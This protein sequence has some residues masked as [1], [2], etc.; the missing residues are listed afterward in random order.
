MELFLPVAPSI[1]KIMYQKR[2]EFE[3]MPEL[4]GSIWWPYLNYLDVCDMILLLHTGI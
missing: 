4:H 3:M 2:F 1:A